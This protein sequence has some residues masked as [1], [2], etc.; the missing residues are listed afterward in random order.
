MDGLDARPRAGISDY[1][2]LMRPGHWVKHILMLPGLVLGVLVTGRV[3]D[4]LLRASIIGF[5]AAALLASA[6]YVLNEWLDAGYDAHHP[7]KGRRPAVTRRLQ[8]AIVWALYVALLGV[9]IVLATLISPS[10]TVA[11]ALFVMAAWAYNVPPVRL[12]ERLWLDV[13]SE[14]VNNPLRLAM[15]WAIAAS[16]SLPPGSLVLAFWAGGAFLMTVKR[17]AE[18]RVF[19]VAGASERL[20]LYRRSFRFYTDDRL[21]LAAF[22]QALLTGFFLAVFLVKYR[23]EY[24]LVLPVLA[25]LFTE[26]LRLGLEQR[27]AAQHPE[28]LWREPRILAWLVLLTV[29]FAAL[30]VVDLPWLQPLAAPHLLEMPR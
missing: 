6:N 30:T 25:A 29:A 3:P 8:P 28:R 20:G 4:D 17:L 7:E 19:A 1:V 21:M 23:I 12:K 2:A 27:A 11:A 10:F 24:L 14:A 26:Y 13:L 5:A 18:Y 15:G 9:G 22:L 16:P